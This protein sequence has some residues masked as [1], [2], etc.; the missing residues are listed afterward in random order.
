MRSADAL[1]KISRS[2]PAWFEQWREQLLS[3]VLDDGTAAVRWH[4]IAISSRLSLKHAE[5]EILTLRLADYFKNDESR[6]VK[7]AALDAIASV[8]H[9][10]EALVCRARNI[11]QEALASKCPSVRARARQIVK[12]SPWL[13]VEN[14]K[15]PMTP[16]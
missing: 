7:V 15:C 5:A 14:P 1:E 13:T 2:Q 10:D 4:L 9:C 6:I 11:V 3:G 12:R 16:G 8:A